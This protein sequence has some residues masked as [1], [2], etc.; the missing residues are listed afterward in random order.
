MDFTYEYFRSLIRQAILT[1]G[2]SFKLDTTEC[3]EEE[4]KQIIEWCEKDGIGYQLEGVMLK[5]DILK[6]LGK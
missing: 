6:G 4:V 2:S 1:H 3:T 5:I